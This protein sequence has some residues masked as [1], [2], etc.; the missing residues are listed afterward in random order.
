M[1]PPR[2][3]SET[4]LEYKT[5]RPNPKLLG[6]S[7][8]RPLDPPRRG[9]GRVK[10]ARLSDERY[11]AGEQ[12]SDGHAPGLLTTHRNRVPMRH[13]AVKGTSDST[14]RSVWPA[15]HRMPVDCQLATTSSR[16]GSP[17]PPVSPRNGVTSAEQGTM[18]QAPSHCNPV[19]R[20][21]TAITPFHK[22]TEDR[23][24]GDVS[25]ETGLEGHV[26][27][28]SAAIGTEAVHSKLISY[29]YPA[30]NTPA[31]HPASAPG[32]QSRR[33]G[34]AHANHSPAGHSL[35]WL[36]GF[37]AGSLLRTDIK[38]TSVLRSPEER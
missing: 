4:P 12:P 35:Q 38:A 24:P 30:P 37:D 15:S 23:R 21:V 28:A 8:H 2:A 5:S 32:A 10:Q 11:Q 31:P 3:R 20:R 18:S 7:N 34:S 36:V 6:H 26:P 17:R 13:F 1:R 14:A 19:W 16:N 27:E 33:E 25:R 9:L 22:I 29:G